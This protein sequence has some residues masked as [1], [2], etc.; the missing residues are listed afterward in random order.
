MAERAGFDRRYDI[1]GVWRGDSVA[2]LD[3][4]KAALM[5]GFSFS[6]AYTVT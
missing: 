2:I 1:G 3:K 6:A 5:S 4:Q